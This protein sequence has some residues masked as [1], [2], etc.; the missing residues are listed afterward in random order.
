MVVAPLLVVMLLFAPRHAGACAR[1]DQR[2]SSGAPPAATATPPLLTPEVVVAVG[3]GAS[4]QESW[5]A[6]LLAAGRGLAMGGPAH[7]YKFCAITTSGGPTGKC[8]VVAPADVGNR[9]AI[10]VGLQA[11]AA[12]GLHPTAPELRAVKD[13]GFLCSAFYTGGGSA[14]RVA[15]T[16]GLADNRRGTIN[17]V[18]VY[19]HRLGLRWWTPWKDVDPTWTGPG[20]GRGLAFGMKLQ[21][22]GCQGRRLFTPLFQYRSIQS[23]GILE[24]SQAAVWNVQNHL[25]GGAD[26]TGECNPL[27]IPASMGGS[28]MFTNDTCASSV[29]GLVAPVPCTPPPWP[30]H[31]PGSKPG[32]CH[33]PT[34]GHFADHPEFFSLLSPSA[35]SNASCATTPEH[36]IRA[37]NLSLDSADPNRPGSPPGHLL[38][39]WRVGGVPG[40]GPYEAQLCMSNL[41]MRDVMIAHAKAKLAYDRA[42][43]GDVKFI[44]VADND[45][46]SQSVSHAVK[47]SGSQAGKQAVSQSVSQSVIQSVSQSVISQA[48]PS[49]FHVCLPLT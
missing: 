28:Q 18:M 44:A 22:P 27:I 49:R 37:H 4:A 30:G 36:C 7:P 11:A 33:E 40:K 39:G 10:L 45:Q 9:S 16:G 8:G 29:Y 19:M 15:L 21:L 31:P 2:F 6:Y 32:F 35:P 3:P 24:S 5:A 12:V 41:E 47:Q 23:Y 42:H 20:I 38:P 14:Y 34:A 25:N 1:C 13:D 48:N 26:R 17:A 46:V 43:Y